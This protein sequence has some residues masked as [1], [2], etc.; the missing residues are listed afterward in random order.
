ML[1]P[2]KTSVDHRTQYPR[3][4]IHQLRRQVPVHLPFFQA[5]IAWDHPDTL[6]HSLAHVRQIR[7]MI[8]EHDELADGPELKVVLAHEIGTHRILARDLLDLIHAQ[9][10]SFL[11]FVGYYTTT[12]MQISK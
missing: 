10:L 4:L 9:R 1:L 2:V 7:F 5:Q 11:G 3:P 12:T 6:F 8:T